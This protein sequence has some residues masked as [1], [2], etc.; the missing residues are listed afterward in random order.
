MLLLSLGGSQNVIETREFSSTAAPIMRTLSL[1]FFFSINLSIQFN[2]FWRTESPRLDVTS[3]VAFVRTGTV[4]GG[5]AVSMAFSSGAFHL[6][7]SRENL[8]I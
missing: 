5:V 2:G 3:A 1:M 6:L 4:A 8:L 7:R